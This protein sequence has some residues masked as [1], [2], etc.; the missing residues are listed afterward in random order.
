MLTLD[1][2]TQNLPGEL[3]RMLHSRYAEL[4]RVSGIPLVPG[5]VYGAKADNSLGFSAV[6]EGTSC[7]C[8]ECFGY[9]KSSSYRCETCHG[10]PESCGCKKCLGDP[11][12]S[13]PKPGDSKPSD[14]KPGDSKPCCGM[15]TD[16]Y[17]LE[18]IFRCGHH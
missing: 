9:L 4:L 8:K 11:K 5:S 13:D 6:H 10:N 14:P 16:D 15:L 2:C 17:V 3:L 1:S 12:P 7:N 18:Y